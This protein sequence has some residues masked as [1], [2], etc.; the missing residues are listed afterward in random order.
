MF[1]DYKEVKTLTGQLRENRD[2]EFV[3]DRLL[4]SASLLIKSSSVGDES[5]IYPLLNLARLS[6]GK[7]LED[8][9]FTFEIS[10]A[11]K[12]LWGK[13]EVPFTDIAIV[14]FKCYDRVNL[15]NIDKAIEFFNRLVDRKLGYEVIGQTI[16]TAYL[17]YTTQDY[18]TSFANANLDSVS[19]VY[20]SMVKGFTDK[21]TLTGEKEQ[22]TLM[23]KTLQYTLKYA[24]NRV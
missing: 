2:L 22:I 13:E 15:L 20:E 3:S 1:F 16:L 17:H 9:Y 18:G 23:L 6:C 5:V 19:K 14:L 4:E 7:Y 10:N 21:N 24:T 8:T 12:E 11:F